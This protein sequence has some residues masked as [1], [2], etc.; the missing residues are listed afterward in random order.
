MSNASNSKKYDL[1]E[2][3][4]EFAKACRQYVA[5]LPKTA[6]NIEDGKQLI[7][8]SGSTAANYIEASEAVSKKDFVLRIKI[9]KKEARETIL[10]LKL[11]G[12]NNVSMGL[13]VEATE[14]M[15]IFGAIIEK[16]K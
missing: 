5:S 8:S 4:F 1:D 12:G 14:I 9:A 7:R 13:L 3:T 16:S 15:K 2:R 10:W 6:Q 11:I